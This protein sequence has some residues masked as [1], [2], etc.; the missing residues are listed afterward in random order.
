[1]H[2]PYLTIRTP[3]PWNHCSFSSFSGHSRARRSLSVC[4]YSRPSPYWPA[5]VQT[6]TPAPPRLLAANSDL[7]LLP[8]KTTGTAAKQVK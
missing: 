7:K 6:D 4:V 1:M 2:P 3:I 8:A 5:L